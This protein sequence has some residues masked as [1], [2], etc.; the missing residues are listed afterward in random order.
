LG[1][2]FDHFNR[3]I[4]PELRGCAF[5]LNTD[6]RRA[7]T[8]R[9]YW[10]IPGSHLLLSRRKFI[11]SGFFFLESHV[12]FQI[13]HNSAAVSLHFGYQLLFVNVNSATIRLRGLFDFHEIEHG[14]NTL[15]H[16]I[17][18][19]TGSAEASFSVPSDN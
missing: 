17:V 18:S 2:W 8:M 10:L 6:E 7:T 5:R 15:S 13:K 3:G 4:K 1:W 19:L 11:G 9:I 12:T 16:A 14:T